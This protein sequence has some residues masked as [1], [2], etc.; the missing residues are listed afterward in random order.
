MEQVRERTEVRPV[1]QEE[2]GEIAGSSMGDTAGREDSGSTEYTAQAAATTGS[3]ESEQPTRG[4]SMGED[5]SMR[6]NSEI[7]EETH[8]ATNG[9]GSTSGA[10]RRSEE[11]DDD[12]WG[13]LKTEAARKVTT[14]KPL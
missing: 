11:D 13:V 3:V 12:G 9:G 4:E 1:T 5:E 14:T 8:Q 10:P 7:S 2:S 6:I